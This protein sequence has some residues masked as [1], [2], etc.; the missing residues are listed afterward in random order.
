MKYSET[1]NIK[2]ITGSGDSSHIL[3]QNDSLGDENNTYKWKL[4]SL[5]MEKQVKTGFHV[6][7][8]CSEHGERGYS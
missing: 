4:I 1:R 5:S 7:K 3:T 2:D 6:H 8:C